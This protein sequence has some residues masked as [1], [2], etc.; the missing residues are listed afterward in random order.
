MFCLFP[1]QVIELREF[2]LSVPL[3]SEEELMFGKFGMSL[4]HLFF[5]RF[6]RNAKWHKID[7][8]DDAHLKE[9]TR[10]ALRVPPRSLYNAATA[11]DVNHDILVTN[12]I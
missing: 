4:E 6:S 10:C 3:G 2:L 5:F 7:F 9:L 12:A 11:R 1:V 8:G